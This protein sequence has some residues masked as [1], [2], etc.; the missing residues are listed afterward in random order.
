MCRRTVAEDLAIRGTATI[1]GVLPPDARIEFPRM[2]ICPECRVQTSRLG[3][4]RFCIDI[5]RSH[6][7]YRQ[8]RLLLDEM[9]SGGGGWRTST[10]HS[11]R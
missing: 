11:V 4:N 5:P 8:G 7:F 10:R 2:A 3:G 9:M 1:V 6:N